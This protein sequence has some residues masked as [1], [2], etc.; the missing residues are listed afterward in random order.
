MSGPQHR[1]YTAVYSG[2]PVF[3]MIIN[4]VAIMRRRIDSYMNA[5]QVLKVAGLD[6]AKRTKVLEKEIL[7]GV[8]EKVQGGYGKFQGT[9]I[10]L[11]T[12]IALSQRYQVYELIRDMIEFDPDNAGHIEEKGFY[13]KDAAEYRAQ[14]RKRR[15]IANGTM[16]VS[17]KKQRLSSS[18]ASSST[19]QQSPHL[20]QQP[21]LGPSPNDHP[22]EGPNRT[23]L[24]SIFLSDDTSNLNDILR[25]G[26]N[27][28]LDMILDE[29]GNTALHWAASL[30]RI[31]TIEQLIL[32]GA[33][34]SQCNYAGETPLMRTVAATNSFDRDCFRKIAKLLEPSL[35]VKDKNQRSVLHHTSLTAGI[36]GRINAALY[37]MHNLLHA[38]QTASP[39]INTKALLDAQDVQ[40]DTALNIAARL[41]CDRMTELLVEAGADPNLDNNLGLN[42]KSYV[43]ENEDGSQTPMDVDVKPDVSSSSTANDTTT[44]LNKHI[45][46]TSPSQRGKEIVATVQKIVD[47]LD[48]EYGG[49]L[50]DREKQ[51]K[52][53]QETLNKT[54]A[55]LESTRK[56]LEKRQ[57][58]SQLLAEGQQKVRNLHQAIEAGWVDLEQLVTKNNDSFDKQAVLDFDVD[59]DIDAAL[60]VLPPTTDD[61]DA[62]GK[63]LTDLKARVLAY[64]VNNDSL[65]KYLNELRAET[66]EKELQCKRL[67]AACCNLSI[68]KIDDLVEPLTLAIESDPPDLDLARVIGFMEKI[69][70]QGAFPESPLPPTS[71]SAAP[72]SSL[73]DHSSASI[74]SPTQMHS[75]PALSTNGP[76]TP[77]SMAATSSTMPAT[78]TSPAMSHIRTSSAYTPPPSAQ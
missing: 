51:L 4:D 21:Y 66:A 17:M 8:H 35:C 64:S 54:N 70:R 65:K 7:P 3:E 46:L 10:P 76:S 16:T 14:A 38:V 72:L 34:V 60:D 39:S 22:T 68:D 71:S 1:I 23:L 48:Q 52:E 33:N 26:S 31:D 36:Q 43:S 47:A 53:V 57:E 73:V 18:S 63:Y 61:T 11:E 58:E 74:M 9:W 67:I 75:Q 37:Y 15:E 55:E 20:A 13:G 44:Q 30:A 2:V 6:K 45:P 49:Q 19:Q 12:C 40:G 78:I 32:H 25:Q 41:N 59:K 27:L 69:R 29:Q 28:N 42:S 5:T 77:R 62:N 56:D 50:Q 24:M